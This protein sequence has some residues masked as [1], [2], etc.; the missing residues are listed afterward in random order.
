MDTKRMTRHQARRAD[1]RRN[2]R[3]VVLHSRGNLCVKQLVL[4]NRK[5]D[6]I[7]KQRVPCEF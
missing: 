7:K 5:D 2:F 6:R 4:F 3:F 1:V